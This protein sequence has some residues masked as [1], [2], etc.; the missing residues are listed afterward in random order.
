[1]IYYFLLHE[2][3]VQ[4]SIGNRL[5]AFWFP[6]CLISRTRAF[7]TSCPVLLPEC[8]LPYRFAHLKLVVSNSNMPFLALKKL[9]LYISMSSGKRLCEIR[10]QLRCK[11]RV[12]Y[13]F[14]SLW[15]TTT[16]I[17][18]QIITSNS[19]N[20]FITISDSQHMV[21]SFFLL[22]I[23]EGTYLAFHRFIWHGARFDIAF[24]RL[25]FDRT[26]PSSF[27]LSSV[28]QCIIK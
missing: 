1:M 12:S 24:H 14:I 20:S 21:I 26:A 6:R 28:F 5:N 19:Y 2:N 11:W 25:A 27:P 23:K 16:Y 13:W 3:P 8:F 4:I 9:S 22:L 15:I 18:V 10:C 7:W 17:Q